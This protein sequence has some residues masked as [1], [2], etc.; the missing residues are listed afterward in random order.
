M[1]DETELPIPADEEYEAQEQTR[2][3]VLR[4]LYE[5]GRDSGEAVGGRDLA[6]EMGLTRE[7][8]F[9]ILEF[10]AGRGLVD[11]LG[12]GPLVRISSRGSSLV[13]ARGEAEPAE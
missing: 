7:E 4:K 13:E 9:R 8:T 12:A 2:R 3:A 11:Y 5:L 6:Y 1:H 10:L